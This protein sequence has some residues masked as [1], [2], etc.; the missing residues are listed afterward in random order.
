MND[1]TDG[2]ISENDFQ[3]L[4]NVS[5]EYQVAIETKDAF[6]EE[7]SRILFS[8]DVHPNQRHRYL[9]DRFNTEDGSHKNGDIAYLQGLKT[10]KQVGAS[11]SIWPCLRVIFFRIL[12]SLQRIIFFFTLDSS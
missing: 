8:V 5:N 6:I 2:N 10:E 3:L 7:S 12:N 1:D 11:A 4:K 9:T